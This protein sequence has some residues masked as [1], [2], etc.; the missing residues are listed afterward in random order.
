LEA[1][2]TDAA[3]V[4]VWPIASLSEPIF[5]TRVLL[6]QLLAA[7]GVDLGKRLE[8]LVQRGAHLAIG[9]VVAPY[10]PGGGVDLDAA[11]NQLLAEIDKLFD[12]L[13]EGGE[14]LGIV[15]LDQRLPLLDDREKLIVET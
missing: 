4:E 2:S 15:S 6:R 9:V 1:E 10:A 11:A 14:L 3:V 13:L 12:P 5:A 7:L 8:I